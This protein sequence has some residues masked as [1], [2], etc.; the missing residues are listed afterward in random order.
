MKNQNQAKAQMVAYCIIRH[1]GNLYLE[2]KK[3]EYQLIGKKIKRS[4]T[5][6]EIVAQMIKS[7]FEKTGI[8]LRPEDLRPISS[9]AY[10]EKRNDGNVITQDCIVFS[11]D[12]ESALN[13][14]TL[15]TV[16]VFPLSKEKILSGS[17]SNDSAPFKLRPI[18]SV[19]IG[20]NL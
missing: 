10:S 12:L 8:T 15:E 1:Q 5:M 17:Y 13:L 7:V 18:S 6:N 2:L 14:H 9:K 4:D 16:K 20:K 11:V 3:G 19:I